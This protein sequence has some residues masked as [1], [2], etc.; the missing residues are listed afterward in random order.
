[1]MVAITSTSPA[2]FAQSIHAALALAPIAPVRITGLRPTRSA[3]HPAGYTAR[4]KGA[5]HGR[6]HGAQTLS[7]V[8]QA[9]T[10]SRKKE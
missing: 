9:D 1:M 7:W 10:E 5:P 6:N 2:L 3:I 8:L 4:D